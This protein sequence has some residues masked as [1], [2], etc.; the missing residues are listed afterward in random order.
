MYCIYKER[1]SGCPVSDEKVLFLRL[2][3]TEN[4]VVFTS[5]ERNGG[6]NNR[7]VGD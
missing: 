6:R 1:K 2:T 5:G 3:D 7:G 4:K